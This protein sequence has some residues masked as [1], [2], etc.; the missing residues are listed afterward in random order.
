MT[1]II[2][3]LIIVIMM[4]VCLYYGLRFNWYHLCLSL[5]IY[6]CNHTLRQQVIVNVVV[7]VFCLCSAI[8]QGLSQD[9]RSSL[10]KLVVERACVQYS[11]RNM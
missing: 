8:L 6:S 4:Y 3:R 10:M 7:I 2:V 5:S 9:T 1:I 11:G